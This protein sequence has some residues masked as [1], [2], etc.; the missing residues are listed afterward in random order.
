MKRLFIIGLVLLE[1]LFGWFKQDP[2]YTDRFSFAGFLDNREVCDDH[3]DEYN[4]V[5]ILLISLFK[6]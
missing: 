3:G 6:R 1:E 5:G 4:I 2:N